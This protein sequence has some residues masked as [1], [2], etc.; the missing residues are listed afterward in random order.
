MKRLVLKTKRR[1]TPVREFES[2]P[3]PPY[4]R[5]AQLA[6]VAVSNTVG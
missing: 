6:R 1:V 2:L 5:V 4:R 3:L